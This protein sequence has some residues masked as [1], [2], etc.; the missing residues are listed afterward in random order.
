MLQI[1][2]DDLLE[3]F[4]LKGKRG[5]VVLAVRDRWFQRRD[6][7]AMLASRLKSRHEFEFFVL[8]LMPGLD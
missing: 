3:G 5:H 8:F 6:V 4:K 7:D 1:A 2:P